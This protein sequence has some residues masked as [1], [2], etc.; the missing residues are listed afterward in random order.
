MENQAIKKMTHYVQRIIS[1]TM[2]KCV[3]AFM[4]LLLVLG[5]TGCGSSNSEESFKEAFKIS[6]KDPAEELKDAYVIDEV[7]FTNTWKVY[8]QESRLAE[9]I[10]RLITRNG[11]GY[12]ES[13]NGNLH[14]SEAFYT[15]IANRDSRNDYSIIKA[16]CTYNK[17]GIG[18]VKRIIQIDCGP[19]CVQESTYGN[20]HT[21]ETGFNKDTYRNLQGGEWYLSLHYQDKDETII[22]NGKNNPDEEP[23]SGCYYSKKEIKNV[24][25]SGNFHSPQILYASENYVVFDYNVYLR[26]TEY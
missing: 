2:K 3:L 17:P 6:L 22:E 5:L 16:Y 18:P 10:Q 21:L 26:N 13:I 4:M 24:T 1:F 8:K 9:L 23:W 20:N 15:F 19:T 14:I 11:N 25:D 12:N 7:L